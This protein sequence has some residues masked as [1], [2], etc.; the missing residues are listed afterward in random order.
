MRLPVLA[1]LVCATPLAAQQPLQLTA[2]DYARAERFL[3]A[4]TAP[5]VSGIAGPPRWLDNGRFWYRV[6]TTGGA[7]FIMV[8]PGRR[9]RA[10]AFDH[11]RLASALAAAA[12]GRVEAAQLPFQT[13]ELSKDGR[14]LTVR[15]GNRRWTC[16]VQQY[17]CAPADTTRV[18][19]GAFPAPEN[20]VTSPDGRYAAFIRAHNLWVKD[21]TT[22]QDRQLTTD[23]VEDFGY[24]T[25]NAGWIRSDEPVLLWSPDSKKI[26]TFQH[27]ARGVSEMYLVTTNVGAPELERWR[28]PLPQDTVIFRIHRVVVDVE[29]ARVVRFRMPPDQHRSTI[30]DHVADGSTFLDVE[31]YPDA[32]HVAFVSS[33]RDHKQAVFRVA[34]ATTGEVRT[35]FEE[36]SPTQFQSA[37]AAIGHGNWRVLPASREVLWWSQRDNWGHLY[38]HDLESGALKRQITT[39]NWNVAELMHVDERARMLYFTGVGREP[40]RDPYYQ[41]FYR[42]GMDG[43]GLMLLTPENANHSISLSPNA[44]YF[45]DTYSTPTTPPISVLRRLNGQVAV[46]LERA[47]I[48]RLLAAGWRPP[49]PIV[50]KSRDGQTELYGLMFT[51]TQLDSTRKY[52]IINY[53]YPGPWGSSVGSRSFAPARADH[54]ALAELGFVVVAIDGMGTEWRSKK[55]GDFYYGNMGDNTIPDQIAGMRELARRYRWID[56]ERTGIWGHSG[57]GFATAA[58]LFRYPE[59]FKVGIAES[60]NHDNRNY[61]DDWGERFQGLLRRSNGGANYD[62]QANQLVAGNLR[63]KLL[64]AHGAMDDNVPPYNTY[65]VVDALIKAG[66]DFDLIIL[67]QQR[68]GFG[69][70]GN[71]MMRRRW[72]YFVRHLLGAEPPHEY[73]IGRPRS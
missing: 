61:E 11:T 63:G 70:D 9:T 68:H 54:Q 36:R 41:H 29:P 7:E 46:A 40:G 71:Y 23:G 13:F 24:A 48:S 22:N 33:S 26:A 25:N 3:G 1:L 47:D 73:R 51:P 14:E 50:V 65:L 39:G 30:S 72:D 38:L 4:N 53:I 64:L 34:N 69:A 37:F 66:K 45:V 21:L 67:P 56:I 44:Q 43:R 59:F 49:T 6:T 17:T 10:A 32:S 52:P 20:S 15:T 12:G 5:L 18:S 58:A 57:G 31:W 16:S 35:V 42:I 28:Y 8:D 55:F 2:Q 19:G 60:G 27:D 62:N